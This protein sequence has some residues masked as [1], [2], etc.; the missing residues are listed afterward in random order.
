MIDLSKVEYLD[1]K[2]YEKSTEEPE[3]LCEEIKLVKEIFP[4]AK[5]VARKISSPHSQT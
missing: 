2:D 4:E 5:V 1:R 3:N